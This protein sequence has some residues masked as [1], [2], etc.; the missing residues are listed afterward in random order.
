DQNVGREREPN[1][2]AQDSARATPLKLDRGA[3]AAS[4]AL[5]LR[6]RALVLTCGA[7]DV[8]PV[9][10]VILGA[11]QR[12]V[13]ALE[14]AR[15]GVAVLELG[16]A[17]REME[18]VP[19]RPERDSAHRVVDSAVELVRVFRRR[20]GKDDRELVAADP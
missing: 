17:G 11:V 10:P 1:L 7:G 5:T 4:A 19:L 13:G 6:A 8:R 18:A 15:R 14:D 9:L 20:L 12:G 3:A 16:D 2:L